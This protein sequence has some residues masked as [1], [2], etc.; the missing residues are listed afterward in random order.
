MKLAIACVFIVSCNCV[1][2]NGR[3]LLQ[4]DSNIK[5]VSLGQ[6]S[7]GF[8]ESCYIKD[9]NTTG[10]LFCWGLRGYGPVY[11]ET[12]K[13]PTPMPVFGNASWK[14]ISVGSAYYVY[15]CGINANQEAYCEDFALMKA[16]A[17]PGTW[18]QI[19][20][21][22][23]HACGI[24][25]DGT[26]WC[27][28]E[29]D[30]GKIGDR[31]T[32]QRSIPTALPSTW[33]QISAGV[34]HTCG[35]NA[36]GSAYCW[37][38]NS[39]GKIG[40][41]T[42]SQVSGKRPTPTAVSGNGSKWMQI[43]AGELHTCGIKMEKTAWCWGNNQ[44]GALGDGHGTVDATFTPTPQPVSGGLKWLQIDAGLNSSCGIAS[45]YTGWCWGGNGVG[46]LGDGTSGNWKNVPVAIK[47]P[48]VTWS[49]ISLGRD[50][51]CGVTTAGTVSCWGSNVNSRL[52]SATTGL[53]KNIPTPINSQSTSS[54]SIAA[55]IGGVVGGIAVLVL[56][57]GWIF[58]TRRKAAVKNTINAVKMDPANAEI[59]TST[60]EY[61][62]S[63]SAYSDNKLGDAKPARPEG[64]LILSS[65]STMKT[66]T[67]PVLQ[68]IASQTPHDSVTS[69]RP[70]TNRSSIPHH[71]K[72]MEFEWKDA[73]IL[74]HLGAGSFGKV[75]L[76]ELYHS[77][78]ALKLLIDAQAV[79]E[80]SKS[81]TTTGF[82]NNTLSS[83]SP[84]MAPIDA[85][86]KEVSVMAPLRHPNVALMVGY[87]MD[88]PSIALEFA[89]RGSLFDVLQKANS[90]ATTAMELTWPHRLAMAA[91][92]AAGMLHLHTRAPPILH[93]D[94]KSPNLLVAADWTVKV[95]DMGL[96]KLLDEATRD[97]RT[98]TGAAN[99]RWLAPEVLGGANPTAA[100]DVF[101]FGVIMWEILTWK[102][103][104]SDT[105][106]VWNIVGNVMKGGRLALPPSSE[107]PGLKPG[108]NLDAYIALMNRSWAQEPSA[109]PDFN[110]IAS[111]LR[112]LQSL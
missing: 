94:L 82:G 49:E 20:A 55:I 12:L 85:L 60:A 32:T 62:E 77:P 88:P 65:M 8:Y 7:C 36:N 84:S 48:G 79:S 43:S 25:I 78:V 67:D 70:T 35:I 3:L 15:K 102:L 37:G 69:A 26:A 30:G 107:L 11:N 105:P 99:P 72:A 81:A 34:T 6:I 45:D 90:D 51:A 100:S 27:W 56:V 98:T 109:R 63:P 2:A 83:S 10:T 58:W 76:A 111:E 41:G 93:R 61:I 108:D 22:A 1:L 53:T 46:Q 39:N 42:S 4:G 5:S 75:F 24:K 31:T 92:A 66:S 40:D 18:L 14:Q 9:V 47:A 110:I 38:W 95:C 86:V 87:C 112:K 17:L 106:T 97:S 23:T 74:K 91:D 13:N 50:F 28:G 29:N 101:S 64:S 16:P 71:L 33:L 80:A 19:S 73:R 44:Y 21:G 103:P 52:G 104:W 68:W 59:V 54:V 96:S 57:V 89:S